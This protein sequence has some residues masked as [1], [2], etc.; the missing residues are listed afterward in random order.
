MRGLFIREHK[1]GQLLLRSCL[2]LHV[3]VIRVD[4]HSPRADPVLVR[5]EDREHRRLEGFESRDTLS[6]PPIY[7]DARLRGACEGDV[8]RDRLQFRWDLAPH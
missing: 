3:G 6:K 1:T 8:R 2:W 5:D 7:W 4:G